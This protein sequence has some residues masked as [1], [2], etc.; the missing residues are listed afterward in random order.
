M[1]RRRFYVPPGSF[2]HDD[3]WA[4]L[5]A[6]ETQHLRNVLRLKS[7]DEVYVFNGAGQEFEGEIDRLSR[8]S[9]AIKINRE[10]SPAAAESPLSLTMA[11]ALLKG[12]KFDLVLQK[13]TEL[14]VTSVVPIMTARS[15]V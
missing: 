13:L 14:G 3:G 11:V 6:E 2:E 1:T 12:E 5:S 10:V 9:A 15:D 7:G 8:D 4:T